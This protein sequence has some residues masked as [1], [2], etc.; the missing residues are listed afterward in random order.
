[1][2]SKYGLFFGIY[3]KCLGCKYIEIA[4]TSHSFSGN[5][6]GC[7]ACFYFHR[8]SAKAGGESQGLEEL[9]KDY[10]NVWDNM[11]MI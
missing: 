11:I 7:Q 2:T 9:D 6:A 1:M 5:S 8:D 10:V 4:L 3:V